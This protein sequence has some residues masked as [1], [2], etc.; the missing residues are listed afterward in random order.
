MDINNA[1]A[2]RQW[3]RRCPALGGDRAFGVDALADAPGSWALCSAPP[4]PD[5]RNI[6]GGRLPRAREYLLALRAPAGAGA[7]A[8]G[9]MQG[10]AEWIERQT[11]APDW[12]GESARRVTCDP[13][14]ALARA[15][16]ATAR[17]EMKLRVEVE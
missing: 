4:G 17:W 1:D 10:V 11:D 3:L 7:E 16:G 15:D 5:R 6:L 9:L 13:A 2:L 12:R 14:G 8:L